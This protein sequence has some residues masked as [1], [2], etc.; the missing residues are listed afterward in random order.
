VTTAPASLAVELSLFD[1]ARSWQF[2]SS[3][4]LVASDATGTALCHPSGLA[5]RSR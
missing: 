2:N 5:V 4:V 3:D 1:A